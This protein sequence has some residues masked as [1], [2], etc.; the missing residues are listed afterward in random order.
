M[1]FSRI[2]EVDVLSRFGTVTKTGN[3]IS[4]PSLTGENQGVQP[5]ENQVESEWLGHRDSNPDRQIQS[6]SSCR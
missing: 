6:L 2:I 1:S 4:N 5:I 3:S